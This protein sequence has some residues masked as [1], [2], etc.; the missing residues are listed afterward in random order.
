MVKITFSISLLLTSILLVVASPA[1]ASEI[2]ERGHCIDYHAANNLLQ[3]YISFFEKLDKQK[4]NKYLAPDFSYQ[5]ASLYFLEAINVRT[6]CL[7]NPIASPSPFPPQYSSPTLLFYPNKL[8][9][10]L[11]S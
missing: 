11:P 2:E 5:S 7:T 1:P 8:H 3:I 9:I 6:G 10:Y 4:A